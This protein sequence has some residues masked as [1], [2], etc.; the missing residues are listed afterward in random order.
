MWIV[1]KRSKSPSLSGDAIIEACRANGVQL[2]TIFPSRFH[3]SSQLIRR[4]VDDGRFGRVTLG[5]AYVKWFR[6]QEYYD[7]GAWRGTW[8]L[9]GGGALM[10][11]AIHS[12]DLLAWLMGPV[13]D[14][15][16]SLRHVGSRTHRGRGCRDRHAAIR[17]RRVGGDRSHDGGLPRLPEAESKSTGLAAR[18]CW[19]KKD[20]VKW[21]FADQTPEDEELKQR[22]AGKTQTGGGAG[23]SGGDRTHTG[24][25][26]C[27]RTSCRQS[28][29]SGRP[30]STASRAD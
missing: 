29:S 20:I 1:E 9:D 27:S 18:P 19:K 10:N 23:G 14:V 28:R 2:A 17:Q 8:A 26:S 5:D 4:A 21:D 16:A 11:Q 3:E 6:T 25:N 13:E 7:S 22:M 15:S 30:R 12:V 24:I